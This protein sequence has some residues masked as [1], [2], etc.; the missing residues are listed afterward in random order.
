MK[1]ECLDGMNRDSKEI[2]IRTLLKEKLLREM[3]GRGFWEGRLSSSALAS[4]IAVFA[5]SR[6][7]ASK[8]AE[9][10]S[11]GLAWIASCAND[12]GGWGDSPESPSNVTAT[13]LCW[14]SLSLAA[15]DSGCAEAIRNAEKWLCKE[16]GSTRPDAIQR[17]IL[18]RYGNDRTFAA[19][20]LMMCALAGRLGPSEEAWRTVPQLPFELL[21][22]SYRWF[23]FLRLTVVSYA[24][25]ALIAIGFVRHVMRPSRN[26]ISRLVRQMVVP[27]ALRI[28]ERMQ[29]ENGGYEEATPLTGFV[30]MSLASAGAN[31]CLVVRRAADFLVRS[32][33]EDG[34]WPIDTNLSTWLTTLSVKALPAEDGLN[35]QQRSRIREC[36]LN[37]QHNKQHPLTYG[38]PGGW[39]WTDLPGG[40]PDADDTAGVLLALRQLG[41]IDASVCSA[42][43]KGV[44]WLIDLRNRD[45]G[46]PTFAKG[47]GHLPFDRSC[48]DVT[49]HT[50]WAL[51]A[52]RDDL[53]GDL[54]DAIDGNRAENLRYLRISQQADGS[55][56]PLWFGNQWTR[57]QEGPVYGTARVVDYLRKLRHTE[58][59]VTQPLINRGCE[60]LLSVQNEDGGWGGTG[61]V[62]SI[63]ETAL[64]VTALMPG[65]NA[66]AVQRGL[67]WLK[68][69]VDTED[70]L[71]AAPV[72]LYF[73][74][75]WYSERL[76]PL[77]FALDAFER[78]AGMPK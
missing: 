60:F 29:P 48:P 68:A 36:L 14:A 27:R 24:L 52:W 4:A 18:K 34:S 3:N 30:T 53:S 25:P 1:S 74:K 16:V 32:M 20:I 40:M 8:H 35:D 72:G 65:D 76:Y 17:A 33:R 28:A 75:L 63:E 73:A 56:I 10:I 59:G 62:S 64:A 39:A 38:A 9:V 66:E 46:T 47:W 69:H 57:I 70:D 49:A 19:P 31:D 12:D 42:A 54:K 13:V 50:L 6:V 37:Q 78:A 5:L 71:Q 22:F 23:R 43:A 45:G 2:V 21:V 77:I 41:E 55:W 61:L 7:D 15:E 11:R 26:P 67:D 44:T 51:D 58:C